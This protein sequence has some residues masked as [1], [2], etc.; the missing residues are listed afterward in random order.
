MSPPCS[1]GSCSHE[2]WGDPDRTAAF[3]F[4]GHAASLQP[5]AD[6]PPREFRRRATRRAQLDWR[7]DERTRKSLLERLEHDGPRTMTQPRGAGRAGNGWSR[8]PTK[9]AIEYLVRTGDIVCVRRSG[10][11]RVF[12]LPER[13]IPPS[14]AGR[15]LPAEDGFRMLVERAGRA[16]GVA[17]VDDLADYLRVP[18]QRILDV[19]TGTCLQ[20][21][22]V[23]AGRT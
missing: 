22:A 23:E 16:R 14:T 8:S 15:S 7:P 5:I 12:D 1:S 13:R 19:V 2:L 9:S 6:R 21:A 4:C 17:T 3:E 11:N 18:R 10:W 20:L